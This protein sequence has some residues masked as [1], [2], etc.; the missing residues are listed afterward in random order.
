MDFS[1]TPRDSQQEISLCSMQG[2][3]ETYENMQIPIETKRNET[4]SDG[5]EITDLKIP[6]GR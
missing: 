1:A 2:T 5:D 6:P 4:P 3:L